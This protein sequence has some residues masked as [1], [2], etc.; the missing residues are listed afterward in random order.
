MGI[1]KRIRGAV[2][3]QVFNGKEAS[4]RQYQQDEQGSLATTGGTGQTFVAENLLLAVE[5][6]LPSDK[7]QA[8]GVEAKVLG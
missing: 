3:L 2:D 5:D 8:L 4:L 6:R 1:L 7:P